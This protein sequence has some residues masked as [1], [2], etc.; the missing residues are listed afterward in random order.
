MVIPVSKNRDVL[1]LERCISDYWRQRRFN[2]RQVDRWSHRKAQK[3]LREIRRLKRLAVGHTQRLGRR[4]RVHGCHSGRYPPGVKRAAIPSGG[5][6]T[7]QPLGEPIFDLTKHRPVSR[8][9]FAVVRGLRAV[10][11]GR[12]QRLTTELQTGDNAASRAGKLSI[13]LCL[14]GALR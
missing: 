14:Y 11:T 10:G 9:P 12:I 8:R 6:D 5:S 7:I 4:H 1:Q 3:V 2:W 13:G